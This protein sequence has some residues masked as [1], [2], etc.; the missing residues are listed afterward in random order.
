MWDEIGFFKMFVYILN[1]FNEVW[2]EKA[3]THWRS[4]RCVLCLGYSI[5]A[6][7]FCVFAQ[8]SDGNWNCYGFWGVVV[9]RRYEY[10][11]AAVRD[12]FV[13]IL[14]FRAFR[15]YGR[16]VDRLEATHVITFLTNWMEDAGHRA[17][18]PQRPIWNKSNSAT[19]LVVVRLAR[20]L[21]YRIRSEGNW[22]KCVE[23]SCR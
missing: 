7:P 13:E 19:L 5:L 18:N 8:C 23:T 16:W 22:F 15:R 6:K 12:P 2:K 1:I 14:T 9:E 4:F 11:I 3:K 10:E 17:Y 20:L 21:K